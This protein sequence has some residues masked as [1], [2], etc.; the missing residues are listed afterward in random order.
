MLFSGDDIK[1]GQ[2]EFVMGKIVWMG[3]R[4]KVISN[5]HK[6][7]SLRFGGALPPS[8]DYRFYFLPGSGLVVMA[9]ELGTISASQPKDLLLD[10]L[11]RAIRFSM[12]DLEANRMGSLSSRQ[13]N[14]LFGNAFLIGALFLLCGVIIL[15]AV[16]FIWRDELFYM[17]IGI[18]A[19]GLVAMFVVGWNIARVVLDMWD[20]KVN[21]VEG[22]VF[23]HTYRSRNSRYFFYKIDNLKFN[24][25]QSAYNALIEGMDYRVY[26]T[27]RSKR[28][29]AIEP[30]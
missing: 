1:N 30:I 25:S 16:R 7:Q 29:M 22:Q 15:L 5:T 24:V 6:L 28:L 2:V 9:E 10:A 23:R 20:G 21:Q 14:W 26:F 19:V 11:A 17:F 13:E 18:G 12:E 3:R 8:G 27:P 4:Y